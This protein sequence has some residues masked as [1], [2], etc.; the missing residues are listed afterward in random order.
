MENLL[1][2]KNYIKV[3]VKEISAL[4]TLCY[5]VHSSAVAEACKEE[6]IISWEYFWDL[7]SYV[8]KNCWFCHKTDTKNEK[9]NLSHMEY[10]YFV[11]PILTFSS[12]NDSKR[13]AHWKIFSDFA[14]VSVYF[15]I[16]FQINRLYRVAF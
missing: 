13:W 11:Y 12:Q 14:K 15:C 4:L 7:W 1:N 3:P 5:Y 9:F 16:F 6:W 8:L 10:A 2:F